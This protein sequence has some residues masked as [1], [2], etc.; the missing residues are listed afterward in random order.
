MAF[1]QAQLAQVRMWLDSIA[2]GERFQRRAR[3]AAG[4]QHALHDSTQPTA[5][6]AARACEA[7]CSLD[8]HACMPALQLEAA[9]GGEVDEEARAALAKLQNAVSA[10]VRPAE[11]ATRIAEMTAEQLAD[12]LE[13]LEGQLTSLEKA[14]RESTPETK[15]LVGASASVWSGEEEGHEEEEQPAEPAVPVEAGL[16]TISER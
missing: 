11:E 5:A 3:H 7:W 16:A 14:V 13:K 1:L 6:A 2:A 9:A 15:L 4:S 8:A 10:P 12:H